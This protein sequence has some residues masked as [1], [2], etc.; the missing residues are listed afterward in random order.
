MDLLAW[1]ERND[2]LSSEEVH[3]VAKQVFEGHH[4]TVEVVLLPLEQAE[5]P[6]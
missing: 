3:A 2:T 4:G 6:E 5:V 1:E